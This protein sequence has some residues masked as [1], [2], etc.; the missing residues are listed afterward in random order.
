MAELV[1]CPE[2]S[3]RRLRCGYSRPSLERAYRIE[4]VTRGEVG[5]ADWQYPVR[6]PR[7]EAQKLRTKATAGRLKAMGVKPGVADLV[8]ISPDGRFLGLELKRRGGRLSETQE[9]F[10]AWCDRHGVAYAVADSYDAAVAV[11]VGWGV[12]KTEVGT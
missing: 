6:Y 9:A 10:Q 1:G 4:Q 8:F 3:L 12:L 5:L 7:G 2:P 11:L